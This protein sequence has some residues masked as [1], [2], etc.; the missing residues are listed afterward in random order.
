MHG[1]R[2]PA[3][4]RDEDLGL[5]EHR[6]DADVQGDVVLVD[7]PARLPRHLAHHPVAGRAQGAAVVLAHVPRVVAHRRED[8]VGGVRYQA[9]RPE[10]LGPRVEVGGELQHRVAKLLHLLTGSKGQVKEKKMTG[11]SLFTRSPCR[12]SVLSL[13]VVCLQQCL[14]G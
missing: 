11:L 4:L 8:V 3:D 2:W 9:V 1:Q 14:S 12:W 7:E 13:P 5:H 6:R 10:E